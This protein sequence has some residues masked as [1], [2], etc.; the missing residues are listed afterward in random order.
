MQGSF[1]SCLAIFLRNFVYRSKLQEQLYGK[2]DSL[3]NINLKLI[4]FL[5]ENFLLLN[6]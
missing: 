2:L 3:Y 6:M 5:V 1:F 4:N